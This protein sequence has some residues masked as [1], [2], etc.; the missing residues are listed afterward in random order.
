MIALILLCSAFSTPL[1]LA[2]FG[3]VVVDQA[4]QCP[5][6]SQVQPRPPIS[7]RTRDARLITENW[8]LCSP[9]YQV[10]NAPSLG[11]AG[12]RQREGT[13]KVKYHHLLHQAFL[14]SQNL[15]LEL[16]S[17]VYFV[18][19]AEAKQAQL[20]ILTF[21]NCWGETHTYF[22]EGKGGSPPSLPLTC[23]ANKFSSHRELQLSHL[24][25]PLCGWC[26]GNIFEGF[27]V[28]RGL[29]LPKSG[30]E[31][32]RNR[33]YPLSKLRAW[34]TKCNEWMEGWRYAPTFC[35]E[36]FLTWLNLWDASKPK[37][38]LLV[39]LSCYMICQSQTSV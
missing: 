25:Q 37:I 1:P 34:Q 30:N 32:V 4:H 28:P 16:E 24:H 18:T 13:M 14:D 20:S 2:P 8:L 3:K 31:N 12:V 9:V 21:I 19:S 7:L 36:I 38:R 27:L 29:I 33:I 5:Y 6:P 22:P 23:Y 26:S 17:G 15:C 11:R 39:S 10:E 35:A